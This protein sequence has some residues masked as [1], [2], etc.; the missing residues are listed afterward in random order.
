MTSIECVTLIV[1][2]QLVTSRTTMMLDLP[3]I[4]K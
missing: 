4:M 3:N 2:Y 1:T